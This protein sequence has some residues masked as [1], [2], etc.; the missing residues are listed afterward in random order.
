MAGIKIVDLP[1]SALPYTGTERIPITQDGQT[2]NG[3]L[4]SFANYILNVPE[5]LEVDS[6]EI[7]NSVGTVFVP[8]ISS[9]II[10][11]NKNGK[12]HCDTSEGTREIVTDSIGTYSLRNAIIERLDDYTVGT[13]VINVGSFS[14]PA[15]ALIPGTLMMLTGTACFN[16]ALPDFTLGSGQVNLRLRPNNG[17]H[18]GVNDGIIM[19]ITNTTGGSINTVFI[20]AGL[21]VALDEINSSDI[22]LGP[23]NLLNGSVDAPYLAITKNYSGQASLES[24]DLGTPEYIPW[25]TTPVA[26]NLLVDFILP[27]S[28]KPTSAYKSFLMCDLNLRLVVSN[29]N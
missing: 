2:R 20:A 21:E 12:P 9:S 10:I 11:T 28:T 15:T 17:T 23:V 27:I 5:I 29:E 4:S 14:L 6:I 25:F 24:G 16:I 18:N 22:F 8:T 26:T 3:T 7:T 13:H 19:P 1:N